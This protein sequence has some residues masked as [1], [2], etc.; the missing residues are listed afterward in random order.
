MAAAFV[1][2]AVLAPAF[3]FHRIKFS[4]ADEFYAGP[5][6]CFVALYVDLR[7]HVVC[8]STTVSGGNG[9]WV[10]G[11]IKSLS[12][13]LSLILFTK[14][15]LESIC[16]RS[17]GYGRLLVV[18]IH[19]FGL[20]LNRTYI[21]QVLPA[22]FRGECLAP[23]DLQAASL[24]AL[25]HSLFVFEPQLNPHPAV[26]LPWMFAMLH[27]VLSMT[28]IAPAILLTIPGEYSPR[29]IQ[30]EWAAVLLASL[31]I[32]TS[33][34]S[35]LFTL[36][37]LPVAV[38]GRVLREEERKSSSALLLLLYL[39]AG[40]V[41]GGSNIQTGWAALIEVPRLYAVTLFVV[42][43]YLVM[44][45][46]GAYCKSRTGRASWMIVLLM[47]L[48]LSAVT[49]LRHQQ[50]LYA[51]Y[52]W[53][54]SQPLNVLSA[55]H[56]AIR[57]DKTLFVA[58]LGDGYHW[59]SAQGDNMTWSDKRE[60]DYLAITATKNEQWMEHAGNESIIQSA[61]ALSDA[62][63]RAELPAVSFDG[64][65]LAFLRED[66]GRATLWIRD[67]DHDGISERP[68]T[69][70]ELNVLEMSFLPDNSL[71]F[72]ADS[73]GHPSLFISDQNG[74][75]KSLNVINARFPSVSPDGRWLV[76]SQ[77]ERGNWNL[78]LR[79]LRSGKTDRLTHAECNDTESVWTED[80]RSLI[81]ASDCGRGLGLSALCRRRII[82]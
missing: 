37:I 27:P 19:V 45:R 55:T 21:S 74:G 22:T 17:G 10:I 58:L 20:Q 67:L 42:F 44:L 35:Y 72:A 46:Q 1:D 8:Q 66:R 70:P 54:I 69:S 76:Y 53:G 6:L 7:M 3:T 29:R 62:I 36:L 51:G 52:K 48:S 79:N 13:Y 56:P 24:S 28:I 33:P 64:H 61:T 38:I 23:Y 73:S 4:V 30:I 59:A 71:V 60:G 82:P 12:G 65:W 78:W 77:L 31:A 11:G 2:G 34:A 80:S 57:N 14:E 50:G 25:L 39:I 26:N 43:G 68:I 18:S 40:L 5:V 63:H 16:R 75:P 15:R 49:N 81:Y 47:I 41:R 32:S 9:Y